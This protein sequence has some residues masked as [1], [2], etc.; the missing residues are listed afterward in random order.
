MVKILN[1]VNILE[2]GPIP[3]DMIKQDPSL[4]YYRNL[5]EEEMEKL[6]KE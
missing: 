3:D 2:G 6:K 4:V 1:R 5:Y